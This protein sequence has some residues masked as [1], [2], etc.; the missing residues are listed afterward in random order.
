MTQWI[1]VDDDLPEVGEVVIVAQ[2]Y[3]NDVTT[4]TYEV[5]RNR[6]GAEYIWVEED[7]QIKGVTHWQPLPEHPRVEEAERMSQSGEWKGYED[8]GFLNPDEYYD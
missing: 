8:F 1:S 6:N 3:P 4:A 5:M 7:W 2:E